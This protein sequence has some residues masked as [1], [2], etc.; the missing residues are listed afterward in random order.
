MGPDPAGGAGEVAG[1][2]EVYSRGCVLSEMRVGERPFGG[3]TPQAVISRRFTEPV[4]RVARL[5]ETVPAALDHVVAK[6]MAKL[7]ADRFTT[8]AE[9]DRALAALEGAGPPLEARTA[10]AP[11]RRLT[12]AGGGV[13]LA[14]AIAITAIL[15]G[16]FSGARAHEAARPKILVLPFQN[17]CA[18]QDQYFADGVTE[19]ITSRLGQIS[20]LGVI[21]RTTALHYK[22]TSLPLSTVASE[23][24]VQY[25]LEGSVRWERGLGGASRGRVTPP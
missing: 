24:G 6:A 14:L 22:N 7:P 18:A 9:F 23:L 3:A 13:V 16:G 20:R 8:A 25:V 5:R 4:P 1:W 15:R 19:E 11:L 21:S 12:P 10:R 17:L 2:P